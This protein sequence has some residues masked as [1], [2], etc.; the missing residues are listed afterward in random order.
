MN[1]I[2]LTAFEISGTTGK[3]FTEKVFCV[4]PGPSVFGPQPALHDFHIK[5]QKF[6]FFSVKDLLNFGLRH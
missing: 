1:M 4:W 6:C 5:S 2:L 3:T